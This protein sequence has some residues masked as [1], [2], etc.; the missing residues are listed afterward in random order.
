MR[1][2][3][4]QTN[5]PAFL[6]DLYHKYPNWGNYSYQKLM[7]LWA[8]E[9]FGSSN[10][11]SKSLTKYGWEGKEIVANDKNS[12]FLWARKNNIKTDFFFD[13]ILKYLPPFLK[14][15]INLVDRWIPTIILKQIEEF[16]PDVIYLFHLGLFSISDLKKIKNHT[17]L[18]VGQIASPLPKNELLLKQFDLIISS[19]PHFVNQFKSLG[20]KSEYLK[21]C[22]EKDILKNIGERKRK[23]DIS[24]VG[25]FTPHHSMGNKIMEKAAAEV[26]INFWGYGDN[27]LS[28]TS[29]IKKSFRGRAWGK[30]MYEIFASSKIVLNRHI[31]VSE[32][33]ANNMRMYE[34]TLMGSLLLTDEKSNMDEFFKVGREVVTYSDAEDLVK[35]AKYYLKH[36]REREKIALAGQKRTLKD[37]TYDARMSELDKILRKY[38]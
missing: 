5:Y 4:I 24:Y 17:Q 9:C 15:C 29:R 25:A 30:K 38:L 31:D 19:F 23:Y 16:K 7:E 13:R 18:L 26:K 20:I 22:V 6:K 3:F 27:L 34:A 37:H 32:N 35:K 11:Y 21:W 2:L 1:I 33:Y 8:A 28:P 14:N 12:Q 36:E 10:F